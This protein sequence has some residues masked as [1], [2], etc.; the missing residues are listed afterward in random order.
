MHNHASLVLMT[1]DAS[2]SNPSL[3]MQP[4]H[5][6]FS[7]LDKDPIIRRV[8][9]DPKVPA[10]RA[11]PVSHS[12]MLP[13]SNYGQDLFTLHSYVYDLIFSS[14]LFEDGLGAVFCFHKGMSPA[15]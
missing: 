14:A 2:S 1:L 5:N 8:L 10:P 7:P 4:Q 6:V 15:C 13:V 9:V 12:C 11:F 3:Q